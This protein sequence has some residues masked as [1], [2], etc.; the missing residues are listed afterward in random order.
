LFFADKNSFNLL[1]RP[2]IN[3]NWFGRDRL[4]KAKF[5]VGK[6][7]ENSRV[8]L[9]SLWEDLTCKIR[10][11]SFTASE[12]PKPIQRGALDLI[13]TLTDI[14]GGIDGKGR[15]LNTNWAVHFRV[16]DAPD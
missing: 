11:S 5:R 2:S 3:H 16:R 14:H 1:C 9:P 15:Q 7:V 6:S 8:Y 12:C 13:D 4:I 10:R